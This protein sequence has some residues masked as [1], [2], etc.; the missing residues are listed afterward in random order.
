MLDDNNLRMKR[1]MILLSLFVA[2]ASC[3][4]AQRGGEKPTREQ[5]EKADSN[6]YIVRDG[7]KAPDFTINLTDGRRVR[8]SELK[9]KVVLLQFTASW[10]GV[11]RK[12][13]PQLETQIWQKHKADSDFVFI[14]VDRDEPLEKVKAFARQ[15][16][17]T[18]PL[19]L[20]PGADIFGKFALKQSGVTRNVLIGRDGKIVMRTRLYDEAEFARLVDKVDELLGK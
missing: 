10:C 11:C 3:A 18:Y 16:G 6:G 4:D 9:G 15:T 13:M 8:L 20:D 17:V 2:F 7:D 12:E 14:G 1:L 5:M 19:G